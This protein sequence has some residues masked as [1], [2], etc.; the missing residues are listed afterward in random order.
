[1]VRSALSL[2]IISDFL[3]ALIGQK[4]PLNKR[5]KRKPIPWPD[6]VPTG[7]LMPNPGQPIV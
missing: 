6:W 2:G 4:R 5:S 3:R 1:M 7:R